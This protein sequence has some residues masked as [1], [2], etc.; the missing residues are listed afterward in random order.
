MLKKSLFKTIYRTLFWAISV[1]SAMVCLA[2][3][4]D[5]YH[6]LQEKSAR[7]E[8]VNIETIRT[9]LSSNIQNIESLAE[10]K[11]QNLENELKEDVFY[12]VQEAFD[13]ASELHSRNDRSKSPATLKDMIRDSLRGIRFNR[14][15]GYYF[16]EGYREGVLHL[17]PPRPDFEGKKVGSLG[18]ESAALSSDFRALIERSG[19]GFHRYRWPKVGE[20][21]GVYE[22]ISFVKRFPPYDWIIGAGLY[23]DDYL[24][25]IGEEIVKDIQ[26][27]SQ[28][29]DGYILLDEKGNVLVGELSQTDVSVWE[30][31]TGGFLVKNG[32]LY[33]AAVIEPLGWRVGLCAD[34]TFIKKQIA[35]ERQEVRKQIFLQIGQIVLLSVL[36]LLIFFYFM[37]RFARSIQKNFDVFS[38]TF[39][40]SAKTNRAIADDELNYLELEE[41]SAPANAMIAENH[42]IKEGLEDLVEERTAELRDAQDQLLTRERLATLGQLTTTVSHELRNPL[43]TISNSLGNIRTYLEKENFDSVSR[44]LEI[45]GRNVNRC[46]RIIDELLEYGRKPVLIISPVDVNR[47]IKEAINDMAFPE[48]V[49]IRMD[50]EDETIVSGDEERLRRVILNLASN[51]QHALEDVGHDEKCI[52]IS[53]RTRG[54]V[55][56]I[57]FEDN[58]PGVPPELREKIFEPLFSTKNFGVGLGMTIVR[59]I[60]DMH[61]GAIVQE[62]PENGGCRFVVTMPCHPEHPPGKPDSPDP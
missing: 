32:A 33:H 31:A 49:A 19:E 34:L 57:I 48:D 24:E 60:M 22:K 38:R 42:A 3:V 17:Y 14:G 41:I 43:G 45:V 55:L 59:D 27:F 7:I 23:V 36:V 21:E 13:I 2:L 35:A 30:S 39:R 40:E 25:T 15:T 9:Y 44:S 51:A 28:N 50:F 53:T 8:D 56:E 11:I 10:V 18:P 62:D 12:R 58:G 52:T 5:S 46:D 6:D 54:R 16:I 61:N 29:D 4:V 37:R 26:A 47:L 20:E 1:L